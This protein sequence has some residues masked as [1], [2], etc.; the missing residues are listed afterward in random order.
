[1]TSFSSWKLVSKL[2]GK[3]I[4]DYKWIYSIKE[5]SVMNQPQWCKAKLVGKGF[6][7]KPSIDY[8]EFF[9][10]VVKYITIRITLSLAAH[11]DLQLEQIDIQ[12][13]F[14]HGDLDETIY[15]SRPQGFIDKPKHDHVYF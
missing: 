5:E 3:S 6:A 12:T 7:Q 13:P 4:V 10:P 9:F 11:Y 2:V 14:L 15:M 8:I 1:M